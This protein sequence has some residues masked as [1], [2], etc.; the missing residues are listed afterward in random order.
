MLEHGRIDQAKA[1][2]YRK[3]VNDRADARRAELDGK[4]ATEPE[5]ASEVEDINL[6]FQVA[7]GVTKEAEFKRLT[8]E[9]WP[10]VNYIAETS[11]VSDDGYD[12]PIE[13]W[14]IRKRTAEEKAPADT[15]PTTELA[16]TPSDDKALQ[17]KLEQMAQ[18]GDD[19]EFSGEKNTNDAT[20]K[21]RTRRLFDLY[22]QMK[23]ESRQD[24]V[25]RLNRMRELTAQFEAEERAKNETKSDAE[26]AEKAEHEARERAEHEA[27]EKAE[28][29]EADKAARIAALEAEKARLEAEERELDD[30]MRPLTAINADFTH[31]KRE[32]AHDLAE[33]AL[34]EEVAKSRL[35]KRLWKGTLF[36][37]YYEKKYTSEFLEGDR[38][39]DIDGKDFTVDQLIER[40]KDSAIRRF[41][42]GAT[43]DMRYIHEQIGK[44]RKDGTYDG[45]KLAEADEETTAEVRSAIEEFASA[46][47]PEGGSLEDLKREF[48]DRIARFKAEAKDSGQSIDTLMIDNYLE[49][50]IQARERAEHGIAIEHVMEGFKVYNAEV[51]DGI[52][53]EA[54]RDNIDKVVNW[55]ESSKIGQFIPAEV[56][57]GAVSITSA[58]TQTGVR[59][60][61]GVAGGMLVSSAISGLKERN[62]ITEDRARMLRD[63][64]NGLEY[65]GTATSEEEPKSRR[66]RRIAKYE[67]RIGGTLYDLQKASSLADNIEAALSTEGANH[68]EV[69]LRAIA[70]ARVRIELSD[71][72]QKDLIAYSSADQRGSER[73]R[74]DRVVI[75]AERTL[76]EDGAAKLGSMK[77]QIAK[78]IYGDVTDK[79][80]DFRRKRA[81]M[82]TKKAGKTLAIGAATF[83]VSQEVMAAFDPSKI[84]LLEKAGII[85]TENNA[86]ASETI[87]AGLAGP[88]IRTE[89]NTQT[90]E[91]V[92]GDRQVEIEGY[93]KAGFTKTETSGAW[94]E[95]KTDMV[96]VSPADS[97][98]Q[99]SVKYDGWA[100]NGTRVSDGNE[101]RA[102]LRDGQFVSGMR[103]TSTMGNQ[104][105]NYEATAAAG[106]VKGYVT[107]GG[108][109]F[110]LASKVN[111]AG[112][113]TWGE[114]GLF[115]T[116]TGE[117]IR[118]VGENG[119]KLYKY[120][121]IAVD[122]G[123]DK[124]GLTHIIPLAT[125]VGRDSFTGTISQVTETIVEHPA[126]YD[127]TKTTI[128]EFP[129][130]V[131]MAGIAFAPETA[132]TGLGATRET[133]QNPD[134]GQYI[135]NIDTTNGPEM[136]TGEA[137][138]RII[139]GSS[140]ESAS[141][142]EVG[143]F[144]N[145]MRE[146]ITNSR[147]SIGG[148]A[149][150]DALTDTSPMTP[151]A[152]SRWNAWWSSLD[153]N[154]K[155]AVLGIVDR[156]EGS[157]S[158]RELT[159][160]NGIRSWLVMNN[161]K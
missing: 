143:S 51:R 11:G 119:E 89:V 33:G 123:L 113:L 5:P 35:L 154:S 1:E 52:R 31:D 45:E 103:G 109:K 134:D 83:F 2:R 126:I 66:A 92:S 24:Y 141:T 125:D 122:N 3:E 16:D 149:G 4:T 7:P 48:T 22:P 99:I 64:A 158:K 28:A 96:E 91:N 94:T 86:N 147:D 146:L 15:V 34:N 115:T 82:A 29:E 116:T 49:V 100:N 124:D 130:A 53:T 50:A 70:E 17:R 18:R 46:K 157:S 118:A 79:D 43:E 25:Q 73:L 153:E 69:L 142:S 121:E 58:L 6:T 93:E 85:N 156:I 160:G 62:R 112:Q 26:E 67:A 77:E 114:N 81:L 88:R 37:K 42:L 135:I 14:V 140:L 47:I 151:E 127:F 8:G 139:E 87:L 38:T 56:I 105:I 148:E 65:S 30:K 90:I 72:E 132:R 111:E 102:Y 32:L 98:A 36:K 106:R 136:Y 110:E 133:E 159:W 27:R 150:V 60:V 13:E 137:A 75:E 155:K 108:A 20:G 107:I 74:L 19:E 128:S 10:G 80:R 21:K 138:R 101:L 54:H 9:D 63:A 76:S 23:G 55:L 41:V 44:K 39:V 68:S 12:Y 78:E 95:V 97:T 71:S 120:F 131:S 57:A 59:A 161:R 61:T 40:R 117:T 145:E 104:V 129:R 144:S 152:Q 84:G